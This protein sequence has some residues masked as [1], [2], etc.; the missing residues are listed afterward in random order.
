MRTE[1]P[2]AASRANGARSPGH[3]TILGRA[4]SAQSS[5]SAD[6]R[7]P[8]S[9]SSKAN[10]LTAG[11]LSSQRSHREFEPEPLAWK[12]G[13]WTATRPGCTAATNAPSK[14]SSTS[15]PAK[16]ENFQ[17]NPRIPRNNPHK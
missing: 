4:I 3:I 5:M 1:A 6:S 14:I 7:A 12:C 8:N 11:T 10:P 13:L 16:T 2:I 17:T 15:A 9:S